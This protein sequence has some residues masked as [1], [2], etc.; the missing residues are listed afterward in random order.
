MPADTPASPDSPD[1]RD[2]AFDARLREAM[3]AP[4]VPPTLRASVLDRARADRERDAAATPVLSKPAP[5]QVSPSR[6]HAV[7]P[8]PTLSRRATVRAHRRGAPW[9]SAAVVVIAV[10][11]AIALAIGIPSMSGRD[12]AIAND[13]GTRNDNGPALIDTNTVDNAYVPRINNVL[14]N[15]INNATV[16]APA[17]NFPE[18]GNRLNS[19][20]TGNGTANHDR[21][22]TPSSGNNTGSNN[23]GSNDG[24]SNASGS[25]GAGTRPTNNGGVPPANANTNNNAGGNGAATNNATNGTDENRAGNDAGNSSAPVD[26]NPHPVP[27]EPRR[28]LT[29]THLD[30]RA[31]I[32]RATAN[33]PAMVEIAVGVDLLEGDVI[34][35]RRGDVAF[36]FAEAG[37]GRVVL[38]G[39]A[40]LRISGFDEHGPA[41]ELLDGDVLL[42]LACLPAD[43]PSGNRTVAVAAGNA[44]LRA[45]PGPRVDQTS[46]TEPMDAFVGI[47]S[48]SRSRLSV[49]VIAGGA[50]ATLCGVSLAGVLRGT[51]DTD[52]GDARVDKR[53][54]QGGTNAPSW[55]RQLGMDETVLID[56][57]FDAMA[58]GDRGRG[59]DA[60]P[61]RHGSI[62]DVDPQR[63][64]LGR[65]MRL[66]Q[67]EDG[68]LGNN[69]VFGD[70]SE[71]QRFLAHAAGLELSFR[72]RLDR[73]QRVTVHVFDAVAN[74]NF[75]FDRD[76]DAGWQT[77]SIPFS[78]LKRREDMR[79]PP[80][81][82]QRFIYIAWNVDAAAGTVDI[83]DVRLVRRL[84]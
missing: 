38:H 19:N 81:A 6:L 24:S 82:E 29:A 78:V 17:S 34:D 25:N 74:D 8:E 47:V 59:R 2:A 4:A 21:G 39:K 51:A 68:R 69:Y 15:A 52:D 48:R 16:E 44:E 70:R 57:S 53:G 40:Q 36:A 75:G 62:V 84:P 41:F 71:P 49:D 64:E 80:A 3:R 67:G 22:N 72:I 30:G 37:F 31:E 56:E 66:T 43:L 55:V 79:T 12:R 35:L 65:V 1:P 10:G 13:G 42:D 9:A 14:D 11:L 23:T 60:D 77:V 63:P 50:Q 45:T 28:V 7:R 76:L 32:S 18:F 73:P 58:L 5:R 27:A 54:P 61:W 26:P 83:D 33:G 46:S 20:G